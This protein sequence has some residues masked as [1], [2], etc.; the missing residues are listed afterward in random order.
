MATCGG[1]GKVFF[2]CH[3][4]RDLAS[5]PLYI[6]SMPRRWLASLKESE[7]EAT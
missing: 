7:S 5:G 4:K 2:D 3:Y 6:T 1:E